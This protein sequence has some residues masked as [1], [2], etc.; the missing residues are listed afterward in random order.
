MSSLAYQSWLGVRAQNIDELVAA[1]ASVG[2]TGR[3]R[4]WRTTQLNLAITMRL[5]AEFQ[6]FAR[7]LHDESSDFLCDR[8]IKNDPT[9]YAIF[10]AGLARGRGLD[11][12]NANPGWLGSDFA[13]L[14]L[15]LWPA[16]RV[17]NSKAASWNT[18]LEE[19]NTARNAIA[20][21]DQAGFTKLPQT[22]YPITLGVI[23]GWRKSLDGL[24]REMDTVV[25]DYLTLIAG[26]QRP[27]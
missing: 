3:G 11:S 17:S 13:Q 2:G 14:G 10:R 21:D 26:G 22:R 8:T 25:G 27:W 19:L 20:H 16:L 5:A 24:A 12:K 6:G 7:A 18:A 4:R 23:K 9:L 15:T 1:H